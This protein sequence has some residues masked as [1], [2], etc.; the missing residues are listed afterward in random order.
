MGKLLGIILVTCICMTPF[1]A[2]AGD[3]DGSK[4]LI[5][6]VKDSMECTQERGCDR[7]DEKDLNMTST[8]K[9]DFDEKKIRLI[10][11][12]SGERVS[13]IENKKHIDGKLIV[14]GAEDGYKEYQD[15][16]GWSMSIMESNGDMVVTASGDNVAFVLFGECVPASYMQ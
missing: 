9:V 3:F 6:V 1:Y 7:V 12:G 14:Q 2:A 5:C 15:G 16:N 4:P 10:H 13:E 8:M 11:S